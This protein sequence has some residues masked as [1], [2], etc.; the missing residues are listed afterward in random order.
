M[1]EQHGISRAPVRQALGELVNEG[2]LVRRAGSGT[3]VA[4][5]GISGF[6]WTDEMMEAFIVEVPATPPSQLRAYLH[7]GMNILDARCTP[8]V[9]TVQV[10]LAV[11]P[12]EVTGVDREE[13]WI[14]HART[15]AEKLQ[16][17]NVSF[18]VAD[19]YELDFADR[20]FDLTFAVSQLEF[21]PYPVRALKEQ[22]RV[23]RQ[24]GW[25][26]AVVGDW[27]S[28]V[29]YP[30]CPAF[31]RW[32]EAQSLL[33]DP[34]DE[35]VF[36]DPHAGRRTPQLFSRAGFS[37]VAVEACSVGRYPGS[38]TFTPWYKLHRHALELD[39]AWAAAH[40]KLFAL[41][42]LDEETLLA[43]QEELDAWYAHPHAFCMT[44]GVL[45]AGRVP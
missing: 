1:C 17:R 28:L 20:T 21:L 29:L 36:L 30:T 39:G 35:R 3:F 38:E 44:A 18:R 4:T 37:D 14:R 24:G 13:A 9:V 31:E 12:G 6:S 45:V 41:S 16:V 25:V 40:R 15:Q 34:V 23:T 26:I 7:P 8:G 27:A 42:A 11:Q 2:L 33:N 22:Q 32:W 19:P 43:A 10:A 5:V